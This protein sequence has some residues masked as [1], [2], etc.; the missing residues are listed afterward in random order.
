M[1]QV[2]SCTGRPRTDQATGAWRSARRWRPSGPARTARRRSSSSRHLAR[3]ALSPGAAP[4]MPKTLQDLHLALGAQLAGVALAARFVCEEA[5]QAYQHIAQV[6]LL[7]ED[8]HHARAQRQPGS[9]AGLQRSGA[10]P[11]APVRQRLRLR[12]RTGRL[13]LAAHAASQVVA[14]R[15]RRLAPN[16]TS[17]RPGGHIAR[18]AEQL[19][20]GRALGA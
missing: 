15:W 11:G 9:C 7:V 4:W 3:R 14:A 2:R 19:G 1:A 10:H 20:P 18:E 6:A 8:H 12:R 16:G 13:Q 17:Y 5:R